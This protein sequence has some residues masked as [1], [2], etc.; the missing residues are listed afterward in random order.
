MQTVEAQAIAVLMPVYYKE[1]PAFLL[2]SMQSI[3]SQT[4]SNIDLHLYQDGPF[5]PELNQVVEN[6]KALYPDRLFIYKNPVQRGS[7]VCA[8]D[9][10]EKIRGRY[11]Y[12]ARMDSDDISD[13]GRM[14]KQVAFLDA[15]P[16]VDVVG[17]SIV[18]VD[19]RAKEI[20]RVK[21]PLMHDEIRNFFKK[22]NPMAHVTVMYRR[23]YFDKAGLYPPIRLE[24]GLYW[25]QGLAAGC[26]FQNI[27]DYLVYVRRTDDFMKR[28]SGFE[29]AWKE[30][31]IKLRINYTLKYG[32]DAYLFAMAMFCV[33]LLPIW[34]KQILYNKFR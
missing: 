22:R 27:P 23:S 18:D 13:L 34:A 12:F 10:I 29:M 1:R 8:N 4:Y 20:K 33:Q 28:R 21:Y 7:A 2:D 25:M 3:F 15:H 17:G 6:F 11:Q 5:G 9:M 16:D 30:F 19:E 32:P 14:T 24:D 31:L 26:R